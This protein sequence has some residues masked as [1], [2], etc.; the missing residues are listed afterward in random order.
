MLPFLVVAI[1]FGTFQSSCNAPATLHM[2][3]NIDVQA[4]VARIVLTNTTSESLQIRLRDLPWVASSMMQWFAFEHDGFGDEVTRM[5]LIADPGGERSVSI[6]PSGELRGQVDL[7]TR[8]LKWREA[9]E[10]GEVLLLWRYKVT[11]LGQNQPICIT[12]STTIG[13]VRD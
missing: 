6:R 2:A 7:T 5:R 9:A 3:V 8:F 13:N 4:H 1:V 11:P 10:R 12:G